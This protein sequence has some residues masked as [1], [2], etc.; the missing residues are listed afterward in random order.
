MTVENHKR[1]LERVEGLVIDA[2]HQIEM[3][4]GDV[5][6]FA[7]SMLGAGAELMAIPNGGKAMT[8]E[9]HAL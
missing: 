8:D 9:L 7:F 2:V 1:E 4:G 3:D 6:A 5:N